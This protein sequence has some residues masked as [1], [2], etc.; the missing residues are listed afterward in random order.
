[1]RSLHLRIP[2]WV[3]AAPV[4]KINGRVIDT[5]GHPGSYLELRRVWSDGDSVEIELPMQLAEENLPGDE[6][7]VAALYGPLVL[8]ADLGPG[9]TA[10]STKILN[11][12]S[13]FPTD[14]HEPGPLPVLSDNGPDARKRAAG[15]I[16]I[17]S[18]P[19]LRFKGHS[20]DGPYPVRPLYQLRNHGETL[21]ARIGEELTGDRLD[22]WGRIF[23]WLRLNAAL[24]GRPVGA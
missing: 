16:E 17:E 12:R 11:G 23:Q 21:D 24:L 14:V 6:A 4:I 2:R 9:P 1:M 20:P 22:L 8:A 19:T 5:A 18:A 3:A 15:W 7:T 10:G 13:T